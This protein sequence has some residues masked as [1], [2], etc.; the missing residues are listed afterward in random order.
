MITQAIVV[1]VTT[2]AVFKILQGLDVNPANAKQQ[3]VIQIIPSEEMA[4]V[5]MMLNTVV[6][7]YA[8]NPLHAVLV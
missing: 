2:I 5:I 4:S 7:Q 3:V 6:Q 1:G 8:L